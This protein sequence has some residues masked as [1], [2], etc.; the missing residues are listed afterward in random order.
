MTNNDAKPLEPEVAARHRSNMYERAERRRQSETGMPPALEGGAH[1]DSAAEAEHVPQ[2]GGT[3]SERL[4]IA[5]A[6]SNLET[7][8]ARDSVK[9]PVLTL[10]AEQPHAP[11]HAARRAPYIPSGLLLAAAVVAAASVVAV[12]LRA[13]RRGARPHIHGAAAGTVPG[14]EITP[15]TQ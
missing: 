6:V 5:P 11:V 10:P 9:V 7:V 1:G 2:I 12:T 8:A 15:R 14:C 4:A 3:N 13:K